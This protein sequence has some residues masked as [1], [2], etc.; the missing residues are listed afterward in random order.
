MIP[1]WNGMHPLLTHFALTLFFLGPIFVL[2]ASFTKAT[3]SRTF[4]ISAI[5]TLI[6]GVASTH[7]AF[8]AGRATAASLSWTGEVKMLFECHQEFAS[9]TR[10]SFTLAVSLFGLIML[11]CRLFHLDV[12]ELTGVLPLGAT[13]FYGLGLFWLINTAYTGERLVHEFG[14]RSV[15]VP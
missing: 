15:P 3:T 13:I 12:R 7:V 14:V 1:G 2:L 4:L 11:I 6:L 5:V 9:S 8:A 10:V